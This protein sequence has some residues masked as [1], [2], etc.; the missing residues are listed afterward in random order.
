[1]SDNLK[2]P[3]RKR[4]RKPSSEYADGY[5]FVTVCT[6]NFEHTLGEIVD[7]KLVPTA[8]G[9]I[10]DSC[11]RDMSLHYKYIEVVNYIIMPNHWH[12]LLW[13]NAP[14]HISKSPTDMGCLRP[15]RHELTNI[16]FVNRTHF[17]SLLA[18]AVGGVKSAV[19]RRANSSGL[20]FKWQRGF[21]DNI[22][23]HQKMFDQVC[24]YIENNPN[25]WELD[26][27]YRNAAIDI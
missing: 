13:V 20:K 2:V 22:I 4:H 17:N 8:I 1:M 24:Y 26:R 5:Y 27:F 15:P 23:T 16:P 14:G 6:H 18:T 19:T 3:L 11:I 9:G 12:A 7:A 25:V 10:L 21:Y